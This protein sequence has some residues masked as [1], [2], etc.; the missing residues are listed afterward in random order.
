MLPSARC[1][2][3]PNI[4]APFPIGFDLIILNDPGRGMHR[5]HPIPEAAYKPITGDDKETTRYFARRNKDD[6]AGQG[7]FDFARG[8]GALPAARP[9]VAAARALRAMPEDSPEEI[10]AKRRRYAAGRADPGI[11]AFRTAADLYIAAFLI[12]KT[13]GVPA[14]LNTVTIPTTAHVWQVLAGQTVY[15]PL[16]GRA[17]DLAA[18]ARASHWPLE[19]PDVMVAG[20]FDVVLGN[21]V[22]GAHQAAGAGILR[23]S[24]L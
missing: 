12:P 23:C 2:F 11:S 9:L 3:P 10:A 14:N 5:Q 7:A 6:R 1:S 22:L 13:G 20:G 17:R 15:R 4:A 18:Q 21:P 24:R 19:F 16:V 8:S